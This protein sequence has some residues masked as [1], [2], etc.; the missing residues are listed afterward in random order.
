MGYLVVIEHIEGTGYSAW[1]PDLPGCVAAAAS[2]SSASWRIPSASTRSKRRGY[3]LPGQVGRQGNSV[4]DAQW[5]G[6]TTAK[7]RRSSVAT[8]VICRRS[9]RA[10]TEASVVPSGKSA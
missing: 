4:S 6:L 10:M 8:S 7:W 3:P 5:A 1:V 9:A 2:R